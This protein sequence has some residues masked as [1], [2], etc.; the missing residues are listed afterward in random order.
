MTDAGI[1]WVKYHPLRLYELGWT[2]Q[3]NNRTHR[4]L[5]IV[6]GTIGITG[7]AGIA[8]DCLGDGRATDHL[9]DNHYLV[10]GPV[11][12]QLQAAFI[13]NWMQ[14]TGRV[15]HGDE[16]FPP[17]DDAGGQWAQVFRSGP[18][19]GSDSMQLMFLLSLAAAREN[20]RMG[21]AYFVPDKLTI[22]ALVD[23]RKRGV[24]VQIVVPGPHID[25]K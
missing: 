9:R 11:V 25:H 22:E 10:R 8:D 13:D 5:L 23:A 1:K 15:L 16:Y 24:R 14:A 18:N 19:G 2:E 4:K 3:F 7:G 6:D 17:L 20:I 21:S 12:A